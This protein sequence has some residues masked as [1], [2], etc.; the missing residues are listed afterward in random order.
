MGYQPF[1]LA[2]I[3]GQEDSG[4]LLRDFLGR[5]GISRRALT[6]IKFKGGKVEVNGAE[7]TVR[8]MLSEGDEIKVTFPEEKSSTGL[9][10]EEIDL[11]IVY[12][13]PYIIVLNKP[14]FMS[15]IPSR[16]HPS[17][18]IA[19]ALAGHYKKQG[20]HSTVHIVTRLDRDTSGLLLVA[21]HSH[22]HHLL[23]DQ[24]KSGSVKRSYQAVV[25]GH[26]KE[27]S[28]R[29]EA[30]IGRRP[31]SIIEREVRE[32]GQYA[33]TLFTVLGR[34]AGHTHVQLQLLTGRT[35]QIRVHMSYLG[36][37]LAGDT[38]YGGHRSF[39]E[40]QALHCHQLE[41]YHP[42]EGRTMIFDT[43]VPADILA[44]SASN[45]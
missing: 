32:D 31:E 24:Q 17:G 43:E 7:T 6:A 9:V 45:T 22:L 37:P 4:T 34:M 1:Y 39:I 25:E 3:A 18:S 21:K 15:T 29:V 20:I 38:L 2:W 12:E 8:C 44:L 11:D 27:D 41:F 5:A 26:I 40:R 14:P 35:H 42:F 23:S 16:E 36:H 13:D 19:N 30:P 28:G 10:P 33:C